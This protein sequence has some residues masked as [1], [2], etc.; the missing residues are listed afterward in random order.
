MARTRMHYMCVSAC[1]GPRMDSYLATWRDLTRAPRTSCGRAA[2]ACTGNAP[3]V[4]ALL[5]CVARLP[6]QAPRV[7]LPAGPTLFESNLAQ[8]AFLVLGALVLVSV[9]VPV[10]LPVFAVL[11]VAFYLIRWVGNG[12]GRMRG[13]CGAGWASRVCIAKAQPRDRRTRDSGGDVPLAAPWSWPTI[14]TG[15]CTVR[16][17]RMP[18][19]VISYPSLTTA[20]LPLFCDYTPPHQAA[21]RDV[22]P[23]GQALG[24][25]HQLPRLCGFLRHAQGVC[26]GGGRALKQL[27]AV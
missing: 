13:G 22:Q 9:A 17:V 3:G 20:P 26:G 19:A 21:L 6:E 12:G 7:L 27:G 18:P 1:I 15:Y 8:C 4:G 5:S 10:M 14:H 25:G 16:T 24:G 2:H 23:R 11:A